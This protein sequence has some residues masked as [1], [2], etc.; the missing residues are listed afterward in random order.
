MNLLD[1]NII[2]MNNYH[3]NNDN[4]VCVTNLS[5]VDITSVASVVNN[6][7]PEDSKN[8]GSDVYCTR[9]GR[10]L[11]DNQS[12]VLGM[13]PTCYQQFRASRNRQ[14]NLFKCTEM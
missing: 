13:G 4:E 1:H 7:A 5:D 6:I 14:I 11:K 2:D 9:C 12:R 8:I 3:N 10:K